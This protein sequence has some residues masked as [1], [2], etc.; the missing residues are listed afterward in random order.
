MCNVGRLD[1]RALFRLL[2]YTLYSAQ[3]LMRDSAARRLL[4]ASF[5]MAPEFCV[6]IAAPRLESFDLMLELLL[7]MTLT[8]A[9][10]VHV[11]PQEVK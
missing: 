7:A 2:A 9:I 4:A 10:L 1:K 6:W 8:F 5:A 11:H 3:H